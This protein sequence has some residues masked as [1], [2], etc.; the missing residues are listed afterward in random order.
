MDPIAFAV[1]T[2]FAMMLTGIIVIGIKAHQ[3]H[4]QDE[5]SDDN[6]NFV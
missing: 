4:K 6:D 2:L 5:L 3:K 1:M